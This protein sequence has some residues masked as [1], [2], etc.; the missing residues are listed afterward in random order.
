[1]Q[2]F[3]R[4]GIALYYQVESYIRDKIMS[5]E[6]PSG[7]KLLS[8]P[9]LAKE[10][11]VSRSTIRQAI[12]DL[13]DSGL[14]IRKQGLGTFVAES[15]YE[16]D[17]ISNYLPDEFGKKHTL[18]SKRT[19]PSSL[20]LSERLQLSMGMSLYEIRRARMLKNEEVPAIIET[21]YLESARFPQLLDHDLTGEVKLYSLL[22][23]HY[24]VQMS[25]QNTLIEPTVLKP[26]E[27]KILHCK[28]GQPVLL[29]VRTCYDAA[30]KP[31]ITTKILVR[32]DKCRI[33][34]STKY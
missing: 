15:I 28:V 27:A 1:M 7:Y 19:V 12:S 33:S 3:Q 16:D 6:W 31:F 14:L 26:D 10:L 13:A 18:L 2:E 20:M 22:R 30:G 9:E 11:N 17:F 32:P 8:E 4:R 29:L 21:S 24:H 25:S 34:I 23:V 5:N